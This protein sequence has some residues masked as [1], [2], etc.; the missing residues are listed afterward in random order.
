MPSPIIKLKRV[1]ESADDDDG[2]RILV[3]RLWP[4]GLTKADVAA[5]HWLKDAAPSP[6]LRK[7]F[8][9]REE[10]WIEFRRRYRA[11]LTRNDPAVEALQ[12]LCDGGNVTFLF[13]A[14]DTARNGAVVLREFLLSKPG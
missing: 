14:K 12:R 3:E 11:E 8:G 13:A 1:Y 6:D 5:D 2:V 10:R 4:R 9:H 7:W